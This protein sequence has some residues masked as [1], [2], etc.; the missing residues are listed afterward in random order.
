MKHP[1]ED[2]TEILRDQKKY[3]PE[4][5]ESVICEVRLSAEEGLFD[6]PA[7]YSET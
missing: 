1:F 7:P 6:M 5:I 2:A 3:L 4:E